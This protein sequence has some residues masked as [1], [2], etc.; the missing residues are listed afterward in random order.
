[1]YSL[2]AGFADVGE[3]LEECVIR[4]VKEEVGITLKNIQ[5]ISSQP[6]PFP[7]SLMLGFTADWE[8][9]DI[10]C[11]GKEIN[12]AKWFSKEE[13]PTIILPSHVSIA[14]KIIDKYIKEKN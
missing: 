8:S 12:Y 5:Y 9:G 11:D 10:V 4:E 13:L 6:W 14:R 7:N 2:I 3:N 1:M